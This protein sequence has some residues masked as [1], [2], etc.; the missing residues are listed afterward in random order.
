MFAFASPLPPLHAAVAVLSATLSTSPS[1]H[2]L[3]TPSLFNTPWDLSLAKPEK[4]TLDLLVSQVATFPW[5]QDI[6]QNDENYIIDELFDLHDLTPD[7]DSTAVLGSWYKR[8][9][10]FLDKNAV[11]DGSSKTM[12]EFY[13]QGGGDG[14][15][16][17]P[18]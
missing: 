4:V 2:A 3:T 6:T 18:W 7:R 9:K 1:T 5:E 11:V 14:P 13:L 16:M 15:D 12:L 8:H 17:F 10:S